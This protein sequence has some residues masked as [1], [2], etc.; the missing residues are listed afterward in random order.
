MTAAIEAVPKDIRPGVQALA[1]QTMRWW[2]RAVALRKALARKAPPA[3]ADA[4][5]CTA[6]ALSWNDDI[7]A[8]PVHTLVNQAVE[9][10]RRH[11]DMR[12]QAPFVNACLRRFLRERESLLASTEADWTAQWNHPEWWIKRLKADHPQDWQALL[13]A[14]Q[15]AA[16]MSLRVNVQH[17]SVATYLLALQDAGLH[18]KAV[19][20]M[21]VQLTK[22]VPVS[23]LPGFELGHVSV[24]DAA[25]QL[26]APLLL[27]GLP[28]GDQPCACWTLARRLAAKRVICWKWRPKPG[29][30]P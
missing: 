25:A 15:V 30:W 14:A 5:L 26:A 28:L 27:Q 1:F 3:Q 19:G 12:A 21:G 4:L 29:C 11:K 2:G 22:A 18:A 6:L 17:Q 23:Q 10:A 16:P 20:E 24:Q 13:Q 7:A 9:A 8:Y